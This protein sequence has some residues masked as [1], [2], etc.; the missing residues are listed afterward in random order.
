M[1]VSKDNSDSQNAN[2]CCCFNSKDTDE[3]EFSNDQDTIF[4]RII[5]S[6]ERRAIKVF[7]F[8]VSTFYLMSSYF[9]GYL[10][11]FR[12]SNFEN[13]YNFYLSVTIFFESVFLIHMLLQFLTDYKVEG[14]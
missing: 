8:I 14:Q 9:Y 3:N 12:Y 2:A 11:A 5:I 10:A 13:D 6:R 1:T 4:T 7:D